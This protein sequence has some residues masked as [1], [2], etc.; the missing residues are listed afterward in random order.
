MTAELIVV[1]I[2]AGVMVGVMS[3]F[4]GV[5]GGLLMVPFMVLVLGVTQHI[6]E[7]TSLLVIVPTA[8]AGVIV[9]NKKGLV[10]FRSALWLGGGGIA[11]AVVGAR[12]ALGTAGDSLRTLFGALVIVVG[13]RFI[14]QG[15]RR[16]EPPDPHHPR[17]QAA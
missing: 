8:I 13:V 15:L 17:D 9:H 4:L 12:I 1:T 14:Q 10:D 3:G 16:S 6:A 5:G 11:G 2:V 7:G